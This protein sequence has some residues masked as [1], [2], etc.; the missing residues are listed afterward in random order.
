LRIVGVDNLLRRLVDGFR[1]RLPRL[2]CR[3]Q[4]LKAIYLSD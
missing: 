2:K 4:G 3:I 1:F